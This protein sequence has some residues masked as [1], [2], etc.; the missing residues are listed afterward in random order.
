[1]LFWYF[2]YCQTT[3]GILLKVRLDGI[4]FK[5]HNVR[6]AS[7]LDQVAFLT[8]CAVMDRLLCHLGTSKCQYDLIGGCGY[9][10]F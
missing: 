10:E 6:S 5:Q 1:M 7:K 8:L 9:F 2:S 3:N 4:F